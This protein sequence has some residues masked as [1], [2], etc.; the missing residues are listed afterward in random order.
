M[1]ETAS[2]HMIKTCNMKCKFCYATFDDISAK[3]LSIENVKIILFKLK[4]A[5]L[6]KITFAGGEPLL[7]PYIIEAVSYAKEIG[8]TTSIITNGSLL[9]KDLL[10][11]F[12]NKLD[13]IGV[14]IDSINFLTNQKIGRLGMDYYF[15]K[16]LIDDIKN[17][18]FKLKI[19]TVVNK[20][21]EYENLQEFIQA[22]FPLF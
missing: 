4:E 5:G 21:N 19:N 13:W 2:F 7:Y 20:Y 11:S 1:F 10:N 6:K 14:S 15:Y 18:N 12:K 16:F 22:T 3:Y 9:T 17:F 8:L